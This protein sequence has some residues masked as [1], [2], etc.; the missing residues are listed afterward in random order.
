MCPTNVLLKSVYLRIW[1][2]LNK[3]CSFL[4]GKQ[5][6]VDIR[7]R[8]SWEELREGKLVGMYYVREEYF[9]PQQ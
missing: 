3:A 8:G 2:L 9:Q 5:R 6:S 7:G 1:N 4:K